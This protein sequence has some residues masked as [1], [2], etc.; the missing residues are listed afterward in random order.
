M[1]IMQLLHLIFIYAVQFRYLILISNNTQE[2]KLS[3][4]KEKLSKELAS[5]CI[6]LRCGHGGLRVD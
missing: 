4:R 2:T 6:W 3:S 5:I 1:G